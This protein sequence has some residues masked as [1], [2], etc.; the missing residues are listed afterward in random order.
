MKKC[1]HDF[2]TL[3]QQVINLNRKRIVYVDGLVQCK[4]CYRCFN[5]GLDDFRSEEAHLR[6]TKIKE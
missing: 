3:Q 5:F 4:K 6:P 2:K 1:K